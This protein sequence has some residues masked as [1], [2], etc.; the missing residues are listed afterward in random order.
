M[1]TRAKSS[2]GGNPSGWSAES[3]GSTGSEKTDCLQD[4]TEF[5]WIAPA[6]AQILHFARILFSILS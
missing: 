4:L 5:I 1:K 2:A 6:C 3:K